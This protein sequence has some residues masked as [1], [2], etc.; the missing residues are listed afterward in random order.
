M[1]CFLL[2]VS[3]TTRARSA[4]DEIADFIARVRAVGPQG[5]GSREARAACDELARLGPEALEALLQGM[6]TDD[7]VAANWL[8]T[9]FDTIVDR[10]LATDPGLLPREAFERIVVDPERGGRVRRLC[11][12]VLAR[13]DPATPGRLIPP[14]LDD[15]EFRFDA[16]AVAL[17]DAERALAGGDRN[18]ARGGFVKAFN[19]ARDENQVRAAANRLKELGY[20]V[21]IVEHLGLVVDWYLV[22]PFDGPDYKAFSTVYPPERAVDLKAAYE[23][24]TGP[25]GWKPHRTAD[26]FGTVDLAAA[27][28]AV[29]DA[30]AY[31]YTVIESDAPR[32]LALRGGADDNLS[33]WLN[34]EK[35]FAK[36]EY[37]NGTRFDRFR[38]PIELRAGANTLLVKVCQGP[39][40]ADPGLSNPWSFQVRLC[41]SDGRGAALPS[42]LMDQDQ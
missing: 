19:A 17:E 33:I 26:E 36:E 20:Q 7:V 21:D 1:A 39:K 5:A 42:R 30:A 4:T 24:K 9:V 12:G 22:G 35:V 6:E 11:L 34:G 2:L 38:V 41:D 28:G 25:I 27:V 29:D 14:L 3:L 16:V 32:Q 10:T 23:G 8:R 37:Q 13:L 18:G 15:P 31:G 40:Y